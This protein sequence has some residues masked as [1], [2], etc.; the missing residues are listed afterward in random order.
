MKRKVILVL[1]YV[2]VAAL[3]SCATLFF[4]G[5]Q[6]P[7]ARKVDAMEKLIDEMFIGQADMTALGDGA[8]AGMV[9]A[10]GDQWSYY[11]PAS[12]YAAY[13]EQMNNAYV[14]IGITVQLQEENDG[15]VIIRVIPGSPAQEAGLL[16]GDVVVAVAGM[17]VDQYG[18]EQT[19]EAIGGE[20]G[21]QVELVVQRGGKEETF[22]VTRRQVQV[23]VATGQMLENGL[24]YV[25]IEN[26]DSRCARESMELLGQMRRDGVRGLILDVRNNPGGY[27][28][29]LVSLLNFLLPEVVVFRS[30]DYAGNR[31]TV[32]SDKA[33][34]KLPMAV[35]VN[36]ESYSAAEFFAAALQEHEAAVVVGEKTTGKGYFQS[37]FQ[38]PDGSALNLSIG[39]Y[40]TPKGVSLAGV[41]I[42]PD[43]TVPVSEEIAY[44]I[45]AQTLELEEDPQIQ[46][47]IAALIEE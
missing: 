15:F 47:A 18:V 28:Q 36:A 3:A 31:D 1:S 22:N 33:Y 6:S 40:Y 26:F 17:R 44:Q 23:P 27:Q 24:G 13:M 41:G 14:G 10:L 16:P 20:E 2:L 29:E 30:E 25:R 11:I 34:V 43:I 4:F 19:Q 12:E 38:L 32:W 8:A 21:T 37:T 42:T 9:A 5:V 45:Y 46:A 35:L 7:A 39:K